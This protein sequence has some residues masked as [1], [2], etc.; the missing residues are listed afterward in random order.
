MSQDHPPSSD[1]PEPKA[2]KE[3][4]PGGRLARVRNVG[5]CAHIDAGKTTLTERVLFYTGVSHRMGEVH[6]GDT[7]MDYMVQER[8]RGITITAAVTECPWKGHDVHIIDTPGHVDFTIEVER[9]LRVLD[10]AVVVFD[11]VNGVEPQS[12]TVWR[13]ADRYHV[14]RLAFINKMDRV[15][16]DFEMSV[17]SIRKK[18]GANPVPVNLPIG[19]EHEFDG[20]LDL[21]SRERVTFEGDRGTDV[22]RTPA[23]GVELDEI[24][25]NR[26]ALVEACADVD[27]AVAEAY[28]GGADVTR[29]LLEAALRK[30]CISGKLVP[31]L[32]GSALKDKGVQ[33]LLDAMVAYLPAPPDLPPMKGFEPRTHA[34]M[35]REQKPEAP[36]VALAFKIQMEEGRK[37]VYL[38]LYSGTLSSGDEVLNSTHGKKE[39]VARLFLA[40]A[41]KRTRI[42]KATAGQLVVAA[43]L[44]FARTGDTLCAPNAP[45]LLD[46]MAFQEPVI[47]I[48]VEARRNQDQEKLEEVLQKLQD[49]DPTLRV[50]VDPDTGQTLLRGM[51]ELHLEIIVDRLDREFGTPVNTGR[52]QVVFREALGAEAH[53]HDT[54]EK[55]LPEATGGEMHLFA[56]ARVRLK[57]RQRGAGNLVVTENVRLDP[58]DLQLDEEQE[59]AVREGCEDAIRNG[60]LQ[61]FPLVDVELQLET[62]QLRPKQSTEVALRAAIGKATREAARTASPRLLQPIMQ[63]EIVAPQDLTGPVMGDLQARGG[64]IEGMDSERGATIIRATAPLVK[65]FGYSTDLRSLTQ[66]RGTFTMQFGRFDE[67]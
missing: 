60:P 8:E 39:K 17:D 15:G 4:K 65:L 59:A 25:L 57:P 49:E 53:A 34:P 40:H 7:I 67:A 13:Q 54:F 10:G 23:T 48:A 1:S 44:K 12:E 30:G 20:V 61:G 38:R 46:K 52:P 26:D 50:Q 3:K 33:L 43:G 63:M 14:P 36:L 37:Q 42:D 21:L 6:D 24:N 18:L 66:G 64:R 9:S 41:D 62:L 29:E 47:A 28:L 55:V 11:A 22:T 45:M 19:K 2:K 58:P 5:I 35:E 56:G 32:A 31:V 27:D 16:A 51:G